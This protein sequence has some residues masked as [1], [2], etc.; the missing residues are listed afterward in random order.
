MATS[1]PDLLLGVKITDIQELD[2]V[3][4]MDGHA[5]ILHSGYG[6]EGVF[7]DKDI[8][9]AKII[10]L[11]AFNAYRGEKFSVSLHTINPENHS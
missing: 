2:N 10:Y 8:L 7:T 1:N 6:I 3:K 11:R 4:I 5:A 9:R